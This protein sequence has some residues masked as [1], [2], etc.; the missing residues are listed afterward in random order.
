M[1]RIIYVEDESEWQEFARNALA[2][3]QVDIAG[4]FREAVSLIQGNR[5]DVAL[6]DLT[7]GETGDRLGGEILDLLKIEY[8]DTCRIVVTGDPPGGSLRANILDKYDVNEVIIKARTSVPD[9]RRVVTEA[10]GGPGAATPMAGVRDAQAQLTQRYQ[11]WY[12]PVARIVRSKLREAQ[13]QVRNAGRLRNES[14]HPAHGSR[15]G[16]LDLQERL[17]RSAADFERLLAESR[18]QQDVASAT[19][20]LNHLMSKF[21]SEIDGMESGR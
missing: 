20:Q 13:D 10:L 15:N 5:Y 2:G 9:L 16:W 18:S 3:H 17:T 8:P 11:D 7:L 1:A 12:E 14:G 21:A 6:I 19:E 4:N